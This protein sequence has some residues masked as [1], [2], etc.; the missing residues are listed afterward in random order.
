MANEIH[1]GLNLR[2]EQPTTRGLKNVGGAA[3][4]AGDGLQDMAKDAGF[5]DK[6]IGELRGGL[7][8]LIAEFDKTGDKTLLK[9][10]SGEKRELGSLTRLKKQ[11]IDL[12]PEAVDAG[13]E[14]GTKFGGS[15]LKSAAAAMASGNAI[16]IAGISAAVIAALPLIGGT[17]AAAVLGG[18]GVGGIIGGIALAS[19]DSRVKDAATKLGEHALSAFG[20]AAEPFVAPAIE[21]IGILGSTTT[22]IAGQMRQGFATI[23]PVL[24]PLTRGI[25]GLAEKAMPGFLKAMESAKP[26]IRAL[27]QE[28]PKI[29]QAL[30]DFLTSISEDPDGAILALKTLTGLTQYLLRQW[31]GATAMLSKVYEWMVKTAVSGNVFLETMFGWVPGLGDMIRSNKATVE[32]M[33]AGLQQA[34]SGTGDFSGSL[35]K[36]ADSASDAE[37]KVVDLQAAFDTFFGHTMNLEQATL[38]Y[39]RAIDDLSKAVKEN[40]KTLDA[41]EEKGRANRGAILDEIQAIKDLRQANIDNGMAVDTAN[42]KYDTQLERLRVA[43]YRLGLNKKEVD[44]LIDAYKRVPVLAE[45]E[46]RIKGLV[47]ALAKMREL[48]ALLTLIPGGG[49]AGSVLDAVGK[50]GGGRARG[51]PAY[52]GQTYVVGENGPEVLQMGNTGGQVYS[53]AQSQAMMSASP[54][55]PVIEL[56]V[57]GQASGLERIFL[58]WLQGALRGNPGVRL[59]TA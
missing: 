30:S 52:A 36:L 34:K 22:N 14:I 51:G 15:L 12:T 44:L 7:T 13:A 18:V 50:F 28:L 11:L 53:N 47:G 27:A 48:I 43:A 10:I 17:I 42:S 25:A 55:M 4:K 58:S 32:G 41:R 20:Q 56:R 5:L 45:S 57:S 16:L 9:K 3:E 54:V 29:G 6:R 2:G 33:L 1:I 8:K 31:G 35:G 37:K 46:V 24:V 21:A 19:R 40:G 23:A 26:V 59:T 39:E 38:R 49:L